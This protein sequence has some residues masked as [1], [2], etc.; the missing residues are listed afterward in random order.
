MSGRFSPAR[1]EQIAESRQYDRETG[2]CIALNGITSDDLAQTRAWL[3]EQTER[4]NAAIARL[5]LL[6]ELQPMLFAEAI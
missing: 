1:C 6:R 3:A 5:N 2:T 4:H